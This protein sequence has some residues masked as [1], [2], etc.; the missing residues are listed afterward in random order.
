MHRIKNV[1]LWTLFKLLKIM[2]NEMRVSEGLPYRLETK[3][4]KFYGK[5]GKLHL[6]PHAD[7]ALLSIGMAVNRYFPRKFEVS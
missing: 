4:E 5:W 3:S 7:Y 2:N 1:L 6:R